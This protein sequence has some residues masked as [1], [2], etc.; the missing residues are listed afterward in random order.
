MTKKK[1]VFFT[2]SGISKESGI[3][4]FRDAQEG[5]WYQYDLEKVASKSSWKYGD[6]ELMLSFHNERRAQLK[7]VS[8]NKAHELIKKLEDLFD[9]AVITQNV[10]D[11]HERAGTNHIIHLHGQLKK[12]QS[13]FNPKLIYDWEGDL[14]LGDKCERGSQL[15]PYVVWFGEELDEKIFKSA[16][17][18]ITECDILVVVGTSLAVYPANELVLLMNSE[19][20]LYVVDPDDMSDQIQG[21]RKRPIKHYQRVA[22]EGMQMFFDDIVNKKLKN[23]L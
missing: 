13:T 22:T 1:I 19:A 3:D 7:Q 5:L 8:P 21:L 16:K 20:K 15:R 2:G 4:T 14:N 10:D 17:K 6:R 18:A 11:L 23:T 9:V 12:V